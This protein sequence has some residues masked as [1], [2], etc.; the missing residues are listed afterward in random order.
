MKSSNSRASLLPRC[1]RTRFGR[2]RYQRNSL[3]L[4][5]NNNRYLQSNQ[6]ITMDLGLKLMGVR[7]NF[8]VCSLCSKTSLR[9]IVSNFP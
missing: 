9:F 5:P 1:W 6:V 7:I 3:K 8:V 4:T 2:D